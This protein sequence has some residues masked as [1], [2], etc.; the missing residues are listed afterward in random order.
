MTKINKAQEVKKNKC[1]RINKLKFEMIF[2]CF[3]LAMYVITVWVIGRDVKFNLSISAV[4]I[5]ILLLVIFYN[6]RL[7]VKEKAK[8]SD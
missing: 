7:I 1:Q 8:G 6:R 5:V 3:F 4:T 2:S